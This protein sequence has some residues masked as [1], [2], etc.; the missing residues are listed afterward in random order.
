MI[1]G[2]S[3]GAAI[4]ALYTQGKGSELIRKVALDLD[5]KWLASLVDL[6][7]SRTGFITGRKIKNQLSSIIGGDIKFREP[8]GYTRSQWKVLA[9]K[10][11]TELKSVFNRVK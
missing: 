3:A 7:L 2:T 4:G 6:A 11:L 8:A 9:L 5:W 10:T 1:A